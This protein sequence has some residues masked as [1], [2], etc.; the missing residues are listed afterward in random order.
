MRIRIRWNIN[1]VIFVHSFYL[2]FFLTFTEI[3]LKDR[4]SLSE[5]VEFHIIS[6]YYQIWSLTPWWRPILYFWTGF[7]LISIKMAKNRK[8]HI[9]RLIRICNL[10]FVYAHRITENLDLFSYKSYFFVRSSLKTVLLPSLP[11]FFCMELWLASYSVRGP[12]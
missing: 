7:R 9:L 2:I 3:K 1:F 6:Y 8:G 11:S 5:H 12:I 10:L 4:H